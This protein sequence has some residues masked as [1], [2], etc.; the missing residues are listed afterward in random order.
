MIKVFKIGGNVVDNPE[1]L[2]AFIAD[3]VRVDGPK[4]LVHGGGKEATRLSAALGIETTMVKGRRVTDRATL[5]VVTMVYC[6]LVN[7]RIVSLLQAAGCNALG[8]SGA[9][10]NAIRATRRPV[11]DVDY[12]Y[13][14]DISVDGVNTALLQGLVEGGITPVMC[15]INHDGAGTLLNC[16][17]DSVASA[18][19][20]ALA[21]VDGEV[22]LTFCFE[23]EGVMA[24]INNPDS[25][26]T[27]ID[28]AVY[29]ALVADG[30]VSGGMLPK[31]EN[32][33]EALRAGVSKVIIRSA[34]EIATP[35][36]TVI[37][38]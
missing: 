19:A 30:T 16:N 14:G 2:S 13:V 28:S 6:G 18:V 15:A 26:I 1:A 35:S 20:K 21:Q 4:I 5:D 25:L 37:T 23:M 12:G 10:G 11:K 24:D 7:K 38:L 27:S 3:F 17:A 22:E 31:L 32:A 9:D 36:G 34:A 33:F 29:P 8:L